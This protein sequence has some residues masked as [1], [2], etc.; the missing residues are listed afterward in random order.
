MAEQK[1]CL[2]PH[3]DSNDDASLMKALRH[4]Q[5]I[6]NVKI[7]ILRYWNDGEIPEQVV[8]VLR[9]YMH[10]NR[11]L[12]K[13]QLTNCNFPASAFDGVVEELLRCPNFKRFHLS[14][15]NLQNM[16]SGLTR[17][18]VESSSLANF[19]FG[20]LN[21]DYVGDLNPD[22]LDH[23]VI[24]AFFPEFVND[25]NPDYVES[26]IWPYQYYVNKRR[27]SLPVKSIT[28][29]S[30]FG[31]SEDDYT[32]LIDFIVESIKKKQC[33]DLIL[34]DA[35]RFSGNHLEQILRATKHVD[36]NFVS[37]VL[38]GN[39]LSNESFLTVLVKFLEQNSTEM[40]SLRS[41]D[42]QDLDVPNDVNWDRLYQACEK[43]TLLNRLALGHSDQ[44][45]FRQFFL[46]LPQMKSLTQIDV[47]FM[48]EEILV[49]EDVQHT[50]REGLRRNTNICKIVCS[51]GFRHL[52][53]ATK[54]V[55]AWVVNRNCFLDSVRNNAV[56][57]PIAHWPLLLEKMTMKPSATHTSLLYQLLRSEHVPLLWDY[58]IRNQSMHMSGAPLVSEKE[59][60]SIS[61]VTALWRK[62]DQFSS[63][64]ILLVV[65]SA[66][67]SVDRR[68]A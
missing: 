52:P 15:C 27:Q 49:S 47:S 1:G 36:S 3:L 56:S 8:I 19:C 10:S 14:E 25:L 64:L 29:G 48:D 44:E 63:L 12:E 21:P 17:L 30:N 51:P 41:L 23:S 39:H 11:I 4:G 61:D 53:D 68:R 42:I 18:M 62:N 43:T 33:T 67:V 2:Q 60:A 28:V 50:M 54:K 40:S 6:R 32:H 13:V 55:M 65:A 26:I 20:D 35:A 31:Q 5:R 16:V 38:I 7:L 66:L 58:E 24:T 34:E 59:K 37:L 9:D 46:R 57:V 22:E 45:S